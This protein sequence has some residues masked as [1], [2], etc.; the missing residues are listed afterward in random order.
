MTVNVAVWMP[1]SINEVNRLRH[2]AGLY[3][4]GVIEVWDMDQLHALIARHGPLVPLEMTRTARPLSAFQHPEDALY[5][6]GPQ[7]GSLPAEVLVIGSPVV[8]ETDSKYPLQ[9]HVAAAIVLHHR[10]VSRIGVPA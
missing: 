8:V 7:N 9:P 5:L 1:S 4:A 6:V 10:Y 3:G 2:V